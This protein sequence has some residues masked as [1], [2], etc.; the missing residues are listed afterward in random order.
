[1]SNLRKTKLGVFGFGCVGQGLYNVLS[2]SKGIKAE[3]HK[4]CIKNASKKRTLPEHYFTLDKNELLY[5]DEIDVIV[6]LID[7]PV[8]AFDIVKT[9]LENGKAV[10]TANKKM[11]ADN[12]EELFRI[13]QA[14]NVPLLYEASSCG[15]IPI[16][17]NLEEYYDNDQLNAVEGI[18]NGST[19]Y[20]LTKIFRENVSFE[21]ALSE[22]Q[23]NGFAESDP[24]LDIEGFDAKYKLGIILAHS[25]GLFVKPEQLFNYGITR[26]NDFDANYAREKGY[27]IKLI[28][29]CRKV[30][31]TIAAGVLPQFI[32][33]ESK[34]FGIDYEYNA[35]MVESIFS[36]YQYFVGKGA[37]SN[38][39]G[40][41]VLSDISALTYNYKYEYKKYQLHEDLRVSND[42]YIHLYIRYNPSQPLPLDIF[43]EIHEQYVSNNNAYVIGSVHFGRLI[44]SGIAQREDVNII[45]AADP[46]IQNASAVAGKPEK[47]LAAL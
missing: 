16:I 4:I 38:P 1:M 35:V 33:P 18:F 11:L 8:A 25:F 41:A 19:N 15:C 10:V 44:A 7:D 45:T 26:I 28:A 23:V 46:H 36:E 34:L 6:E 42:F 3:I 37:G 22:A 24:S 47:E 43:R 5:N 12:F 14:S 29:F 9:A 30:G 27:K 20:I 32:S 39:T 21:T 31:S 2:H 13:Q 40:S 17:R